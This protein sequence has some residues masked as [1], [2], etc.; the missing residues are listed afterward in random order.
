MRE[1]SSLINSLR[2]V[3]PM[4]ATVW[5]ALH[6]LG[7]RSPYV[8]QGIRPIL[9]D[10]VL[11]GPALTVDYKPMNEVAIAITEDEFRRS[12]IFEA[13]DMTKP[14]DVVV[15]GAL[16][17][18][19]GM[20]GDCITL[21]FITK[22]AEGIVIDGGVRD[23]PVIRR[24]YKFPVFAKNVTPFAGQVFPSRVNV[25]VNCGGVLVRP[26]DIIAGDDDGV[27]VIPLHLLRAV[28]E[29]AEREVHLED[30]VRRRIKEELPKGTG[31]GELYPPRGDGAK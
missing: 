2:K 24:V 5:G 7:V 26:G 28:V 23:S 13:C 22:G 20:V 14:G 17:D 1:V 4:T 21:G 27:V 8:M 15:L 18:P 10:S 6:K 11:V 31:L 25:P 19:S 30:A 29:H 3:F 16:G 12:A 9:E